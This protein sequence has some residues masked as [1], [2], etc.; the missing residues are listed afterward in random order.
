[1]TPTRTTAFLFLAVGLI[2]FSLPLAGNSAAA[3][4]SRDRS[5]EKSGSA[6]KKTTESPAKSPAKPK[7]SSEASGFAAYEIIA[8]RNV[9]N[10]NRS[11]SKKNDDGDKPEPT[12]APPT[13]DLLG[14]WVTDRQAVAFIE[15][16][17]ANLNG[18]P[19]VGDRV[20]GWTIGAI[21]TE[22]VV[23]EKEEQK[24]SWPVG[25][26]LERGEGG[27]WKLAGAASPHAKTS[28]SSTGSSSA[29]S[30][31]DDNAGSDDMLKLM[32]ERRQREMKK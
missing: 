20:A 1:M 10:P 13:V 2:A 7:A 8:Q 27:E 26:R 17:D 21:D 22:K 4:R 5:N 31:A 9:F 30:R 25:R 16:A 11:A 14:T 15:G 6:S 19:G 24:I 12:P 28:S 29:S 23:L 18:A 32:R 3:Q